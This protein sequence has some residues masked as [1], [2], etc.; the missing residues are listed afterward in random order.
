MSVC[1]R[2][3]VVLLI[4]S[5]TWVTLSQAVARLLPDNGQLLYSEPYT[6]TLYLLDVRHN[7][8]IE[9]SVRGSMASWSPDRLYIA[10][11]G[12]RRTSAEIEVLDLTTGTLTQLTHN[13]E[14]DGSPAWSPDGRSIA[15]VSARDGDYDVFL[16]TPEGGD[17]RNLTNN[18]D[19][20]DSP[21]WSPDSRYIA[22]E[23]NRTGHG[24]IYIMDV[25]QPDL[26]TRALTDGQV[27]AKN[28]TWSP[29]GT[30]IAFEYYVNA[31]AD[32]Y[33][34]QID[35]SDLRDLTNFPEAHD[36][37]PAWSPDSQA[38]AFVSSRPLYRQIFV[39]NAAFNAAIDFVPLNPLTNGDSD[40]GDLVWQ[41]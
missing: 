2:L 33:V 10:L 7:L 40:K 29:D 16:M 19:Y 22:F 31:Y 41:P 4:L 30:Q 21:T 8:Q 20:D 12:H 11:V 14:Y 32:I 5:A 34:M 3:S 25:T 24:A 39:V 27:W 37:S 26:P 6:D 36:L 35:G 17:V 23:S 28:P 18:H 9:L 1:L 38:I 13:S 15:F